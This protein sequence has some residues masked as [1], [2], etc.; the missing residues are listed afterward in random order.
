MAAPRPDIIDDIPRCSPKCPK[1]RT[2]E[3]EPLC[4]ETGNNWPQ[5]RTCYP[6]VQRLVREARK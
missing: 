6:E 5:G 2:S 4:E 1:Y 3:R